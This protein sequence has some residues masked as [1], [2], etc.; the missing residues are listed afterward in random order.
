MN[1]KRAI[2]IV[3]LLLIFIIATKIL[4]ILFRLH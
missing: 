1:E 2:Q 3:Y 4:K